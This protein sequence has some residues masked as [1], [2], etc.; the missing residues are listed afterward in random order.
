MRM[1][2]WMCDHTKKDKIRNDY[3]WEKIGV[4]PIEE[5]MTKNKF[6]CFGQVQ[7]RQREAPV[8]QV[9][10][11]VFSPVERRKGRTK[12]TFFLEEVVKGN[13]RI[14]NISDTLVFNCAE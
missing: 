14:N 13:L 12:S 6:R 11:R 8:G 7:R 2:R 4:A 3:I 1:L 10:C 9:V 5:K